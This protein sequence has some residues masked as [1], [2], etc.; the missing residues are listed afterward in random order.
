MFKTFTIIVASLALILGSVFV[1]GGFDSTVA[2]A[3]SP[4]ACCEVCQCDTCVCDA[5][6]CCLPDGECV[7]DEACCT[8]CSVE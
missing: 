3:T 6:G 8:Q 1:L 5:S 2:A 4:C 7:C